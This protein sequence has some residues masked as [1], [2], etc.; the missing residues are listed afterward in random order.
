MTSG[1]EKQTN[2]LYFNV[3]DGSFRTKCE[4][5]HPEA[6]AREYETKDKVKSVKYELKYSAL[7]GRI[8]N[9]FFKD[10]DFGKSVNIVLEPN[11]DGVNPIIQLGTG[12][13][14][15]EDFLKKLPNVDLEKPVRLM[16]YAFTTEDG[17]ERRGITIT[18]TNADTQKFTDKVE[19]F[20]YD[21]EAKTAKNGYPSPMGDTKSYDKED[22]KIFYLQ[23]R[24]FLIQYT[25]KNILPKFSK[26]KSVATGDIDY[27][28]TEI[29]PDDVPF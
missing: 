26:I 7:F 3:V 28:T 27:P 8:E 16:P 17:K 10:G 9:I 15:G 12:T 14:Y 5:D 24:K 2:G 29:N 13:N 11:D 21:A 18:H 19:G 1:M 20:F 4:K 25:E 22:W 6:I 23:A